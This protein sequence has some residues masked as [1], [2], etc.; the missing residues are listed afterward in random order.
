MICTADTTELGLLAAAQAAWTAEATGRV[1][2]AVEEHT[3][4]LHQEVE[5]SAR[6]SFLRGYSTGETAGAVT[7]DVVGLTGEVGTDAIQGR[8]QEYGTVHHDPQP[9]IT[10]PLKRREPHFVDRMGSI[11]S[12]VLW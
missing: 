12:E 8:M 3:E 1:R 7:S 4:R 10:P 2:K 5:Q 6:G 11:A 9:W